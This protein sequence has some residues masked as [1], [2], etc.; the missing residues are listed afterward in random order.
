MLLSP[1]A[2][3]AVQ[4]PLLV[5]AAAL[6]LHGE[7]IVRW[8]RVLLLGLGWLLVE[9]LAQPLVVT[10]D[11]P[12]AD[13]P[14]VPAL[15]VA[16]LLV[17]L[18]AAGNEARGGPAGVDRPVT[19][20]V[21][22]TAAFLVM[23]E[24][25]GL[26]VAV[27]GWV[28]GTL[29]LAWVLTAGARRHPGSLLAARLRMLAAAQ[30]LLAS[31]SLSL[32][33]G[34]FLLVWVLPMLTGTS[35]V[36][37]AVAL[38][39]A[40]RIVPRRTRVALREVETEIVAIEAV[41]PVALELMAG[42]LQDLF[43]AD[44]VVVTDGDRVVA[45]AGDPT[46]FVEGADAH[47]HVLRASTGRG[48][49]AIA[50]PPIAWL[51]SRSDR[52][53]VVAFAERLGLVLT[54][55]DARRAEARAA[56]ARDAAARVRDDV[57]STLSHELRTPLTSVMGFAEV[58]LEHRDRL[59]AD[60]HDLLLSRIA[61]RSRHLEVLVERLLSLTAVR[62][63]GLVTAAEEHP[64]GALLDVAA[65]RSGHAHRVEVESAAR[66]LVLHTDGAAVV[67]VVEELFRNAVKFGPPATPV[68]VRV[69]EAD[70]RVHV[71]VH[72]QGPGLAELGDTAFEPFTR[73]GE[74]L[75]RETGGLGIG[76]TIARELARRLGG[77]LTVVTDA[78][79]GCVRFTLPRRHEHVAPVTPVDADRLVAENVMP[80]A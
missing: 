48:E 17:A 47:P 53:Q 19:G 11:G 60:Q 62:G 56:A 73:G 30:V 52:E 72:D 37:L 68:T 49:L 4:V 36:A 34:P 23:P 76:L 42:H 66:D 29:R 31:A 20:I 63:R 26:L 2:A 69:A 40:V 35:I 46:G 13:V 32:L 45:T 39:P 5:A 51:L 7:P 21:A 16:G 3:V 25:F 12:L 41:G 77:D 58:L 27:A 75:T 22:L 28:V 24:Q 80:A 78:P 15:V 55:D 1:L 79:G 61:D 9:A 50:L 43:A 6:L 59:P 57:V 67:D 18:L 33:G 44:G 38:P 54:R 71:D 14:V 10:A 70:D 8:L 64:L 65:R 74:L